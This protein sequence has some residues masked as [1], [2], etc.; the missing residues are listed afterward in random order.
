MQGE[1]LIEE[2]QIQLDFLTKAYK[3]KRALSEF[4]SFNQFTIPSSVD[5]AYA[6]SKVNLPKFTFYY[7]MVWGAFLMLVLLTHPI[8]I[9][10][11]VF[12]GAMF[13]ASSVQLKIKEVEIT[14]L[15]ALYGCIGFNVFLMLIFKSIAHSFL[16]VLSS[17]SI[18]AILILLHASLS[19]EVESETIENI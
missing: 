3:N 10:P 12:S 2:Q 17:S 19:K 14:P 16:M 13:Y 5:E 8:L 18:A 11:V 6:R 4:L 1:L 9:V 15:Y 7:L